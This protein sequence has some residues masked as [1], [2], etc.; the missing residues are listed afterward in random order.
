[1]NAY[2][3]T[4]K[5]LD[6][7]FGALIKSQAPERFSQKHLENMGFKSTNDRLF[8]GLLKGLNFIDENGVPTQ[9]Y[10]KFLDASES[11]KILAVAVKEAYSD[12]FTLNKEA[13]KLTYEEVKNKFKSLTEGKKSENVIALM[14]TT[15]K[16]LSDWADFKTKEETPEKEN[17]KTIK[18]SDQVTPDTKTN[19]IGLEPTLHYNIQIHLPETKDYQVYDAIFRAMKEHLNL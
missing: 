17:Q 11:K 7:F 1:M 13:Y 2:L 9:R 16:A 6:Q 19:K 15:F 10:S 12:I 3:Q 18:P 5:N 4:A 8:I 14:A